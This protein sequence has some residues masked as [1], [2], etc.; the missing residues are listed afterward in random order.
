[1]VRNNKKEVIKNMDEISKEKIIKNIQEFT[2]IANEPL[3]TTELEK[4]LIHDLIN[5][6]DDKLINRCTALFG[7]INMIKL[8]QIV[9]LLQ[10]FRTLFLVDK[11][12]NK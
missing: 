8:K 2:K 1:M 9:I 5:T 6:K 7:L 4:S 11:S 10:E 12:I 3:L